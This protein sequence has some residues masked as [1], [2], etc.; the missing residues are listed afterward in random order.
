MQYLVAKYRAA[1]I[2]PM[3][4]NTNN[5]DRLGYYQVGQNKFYNK[6]LALIHSYRSR[7]KITWVFN[8]DVYGAID[9][10]VPVESSL[11]ELYHA[12]HSN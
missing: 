4:L 5:T 1:L 12:A 3:P 2:I 11:T 10:T 7:Q 8:D 6:T 9:W